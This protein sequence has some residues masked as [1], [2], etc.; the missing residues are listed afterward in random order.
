MK[1][2]IGTANFSNRYG[3]NNS[4]IEK[5]KITEI[6]QYCKKKS[7]KYFDCSFEYNN[8]ESFHKNILSHNAKIYL[9]FKL[10]KDTKKK[11][12]IKK[13]INKINNFIK[14]NIKLYCLMFHDIN[15]LKNEN[16]NSFLDYISNLRK[17]KKIKK[18]GI[19]IYHPDELKVIKK[20]NFNFDY[21]Q[22]PLNIFNQNF[23]N[24]NTEFLRRKGTK[25][26]ARSIFLQGA[27]F[28]EKFILKHKEICNKISLINKNYKNYSIQFVL[29]NFVKN[30]KWLNGVIIGVDSKIHLKEVH[31]NFM[32]RV[33]INIK[34]NKY[35]IINN[36]IIDPRSWK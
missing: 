8:I 14:K 28:N 29:I 30:I 10:E 31:K 3:I 32:S 9:K 19:S 23:N 22:I 27:V 18:I 33:P 5:K 34:I 21:I 36:K 13:T 17:Q 16:I 11:N 20:K 26:L 12:S 15:D 1:L 6:F 35:K 4:S 25:F 2:I 24:K 7:I